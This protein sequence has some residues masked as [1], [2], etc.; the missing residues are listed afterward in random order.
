MLLPTAQEV[1]SAL[2]RVASSCVAALRDD[3]MH[4]S[5]RAVHQDISD[6]SGLWLAQVVADA[7]EEVL[8][9]LASEEQAMSAARQNGLQNGNKPAV[10]AERCRAFLDGLR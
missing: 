9:M 4:I 7:N 5:A 1:S 10:T 6:L 3:A 2:E 8:M